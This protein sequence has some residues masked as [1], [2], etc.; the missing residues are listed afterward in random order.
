MHK[1]RVGQRVQLVGPTRMLTPSQTGYEVVR[2]LPENEGEPSY[3]IK[4]RGETHERVAKESQLR[5]F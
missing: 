5:Q 2:Q 1:F 3:R 4:S